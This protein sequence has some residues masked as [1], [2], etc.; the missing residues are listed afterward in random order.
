MYRAELIFPSIKIIGNFV[1]LNM[2]PH[3]TWQTITV[4]HPHNAPRARDQKAILWKM[5]RSVAIIICDI[6]VN[7]DLA[8]ALSSGLRHCGYFRPGWC[9][10]PSPA[11][12]SI[13][14]FGIQ[15]PWLARP[16]TT[17]VQI[18][19]TSLILWVFLLKWPEGHA[20]RLLLLWLLT[21]KLSLTVQLDLRH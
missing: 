8:L 7:F 16:D 20:K 6:E 10:C 21:L 9:N 14:P 4:L 3:H 15:A 13:L 18:R 17:E 19:M 12:I 2:K 1:P 5:E 11:C